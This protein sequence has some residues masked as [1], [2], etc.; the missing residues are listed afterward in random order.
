MHKLIHTNKNRSGDN[1]VIITDTRKQRSQQH[2][3]QDAKDR[4]IRE[5]AEGVEEETEGLVELEDLVEAEEVEHEVEHEVVD[6]EHC[7]WMVCEIC[8]RG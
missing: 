4:N 7:R 1:N 3:S 6:E 8:M 5:V 2:S